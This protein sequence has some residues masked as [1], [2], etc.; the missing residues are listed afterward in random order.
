[1]GQPPRARPD[2][3]AP[4]GRPEDWPERPPLPGT[5]TGELRSPHADQSTRVAFANAFPRLLRLYWLD[6]HSTTRG[7]PGSPANSARA[8]PMCSRPSGATPGSPSTRAR[9]R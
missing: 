5:M 6:Y 4:T 9:L 7:R 3:R 2:L 1:M 8:R